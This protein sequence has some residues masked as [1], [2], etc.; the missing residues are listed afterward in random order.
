MGKIDFNAMKK[1]RAEKEIEAEVPEALMQSYTQVWGK[2]KETV[3]YIELGRLKAFSD[4]RGRTQP[5]TISPEKVEQIKVSASD[6]GIVTPL[7]VRKYEGDY[8]II[9]GHHRYM[10][11]QE[12]DLVTVPCVIRDI[13]DNEAV[14]YVAES[15]IQRSKL[16]PTEYAEIYARYMEIRSDIDMTAQEIADKFGISRKSLYRYIKINDLTD[17]LKN[18]IDKDMLH[19]D[20]AEIFA[21]FSD[22]Q[23]ELVYDFVQET[24]KKVNRALAKRM[25]GIVAANGDSTTLDSFK[26]L[27]NE[28][29]PTC[30]NKTYIE[31][32]KKYNVSYSDDEWTSLIDELLAQ[33]FGKE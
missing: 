31:L 10:A 1:E 13:K 3:E 14:K 2:D 32:G 21:D 28:P 15:N 11:A 12:L 25:Q 33:H 26:N 27:L 9:S 5:F 6:I 30:S 8:Q 24:G 22:E 29:K 7:I 20:T 23:Q 17:N 18:L 19:T 4:T 16:L